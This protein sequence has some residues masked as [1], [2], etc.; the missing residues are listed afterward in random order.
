[1]PKKS[2]VAAYFWLK[3]IRRQQSDESQAYNSVETVKNK[4]GEPVE[5]SYAANSI[6]YQNS[7]AVLLTIEPGT[8]QLAQH[9]ERAYTRNG[10]ASGFFNEK[11]WDFRISTE[12]IIR[13][14]SP[15]CALQGVKDIKVGDNIFTAIDDTN[16]FAEESILSQMAHGEV[17]S[18]K[19]TIRTNNGQ[20]TTFEVML[21]TELWTG[22]DSDDYYL[23]LLKVSP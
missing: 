14:I 10:A 23:A 16:N 17:I 5:I 6:R 11:L 8:H 22:E 12:G 4:A 18:T 7:W 21:R 1:M 3:K 19:V 15:H 9:W 20:P 2:L 13:E